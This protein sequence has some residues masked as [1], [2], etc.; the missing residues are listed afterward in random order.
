M[1]KSEKL[2]LFSLAITASSYAAFWRTGSHAVLFSILFVSV[3]ISI[4]A[5]CIESDGQ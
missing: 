5:M 3:V 4:W 2:T 1:K